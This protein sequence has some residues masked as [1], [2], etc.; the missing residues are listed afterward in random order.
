MCRRFSSFSKF[1][2]IQN[3]ENVVVAFCGLKYIIIVG[4]RIIRVGVKTTI[5]YTKLKIN[6]KYLLYKINSFVI[7]SG[8]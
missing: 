6:I 7:K 5:I 4:F 3:D 2:C 8:Y 1:A